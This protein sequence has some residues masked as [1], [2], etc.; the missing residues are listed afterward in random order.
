MIVFFMDLC[1]LL[2]GKV[3][4]GRYIFLSKPQGPALYILP[5]SFERTLFEI[6]GAFISIPIFGA[7]LF[8]SS[9][10][11]SRESAPNSLQP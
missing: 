1:N 8:T 11:L 3:T 6:G 4:N 7:I 2:H 9:I 10:A 5:R